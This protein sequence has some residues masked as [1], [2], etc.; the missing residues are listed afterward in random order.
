MAMTT[1]GVIV[2]MPKRATK[3]LA[4]QIAAPDFRRAVPREIPTPK[5]ATVPQLICGTASFQLMKPMRGS[6]ISMMPVMVT[7]VVSNG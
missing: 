6:I 7:V 4:S 5:R 2:S 3:W 1:S